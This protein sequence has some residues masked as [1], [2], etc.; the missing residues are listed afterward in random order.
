MG[1][2]D[3]PRRTARLPPRRHPSAARAV[4]GPATWMTGARA[5]RPGQETRAQATPA[6]PPRASGPGSASK[7]PLTGQSSIL[8]TRRRRIAQQRRAAVL[9]WRRDD[10]RRARIPAALGLL[11]SQVLLRLIR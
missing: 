6:R 10:G 9:T 5:T 4:A 11:R 3:R 7:G 8:Y 1:R 2:P